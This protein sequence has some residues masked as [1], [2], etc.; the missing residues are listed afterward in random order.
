[1]KA[2]ILNNINDIKLSEVDKPICK[3]DRVL[4]K[5]KAAGICSSDIQRVFKTGAYHYPIILGHEFSG[6]TEDGKR[7]AVFPLLPCHSCESCKSGHYE[8]C[9]NYSYLGSR[10]DGAFSEY[11]TVPKWNLIELN[12][13]VSYE[14]AALLEPAAVGLHA[15]KKIDK[16]EKTMKVAVIGN[17]TIGELIGKWLKVFGVQNIDIIGRNDI[18]KNA[19][20][21][22]CFE[23]VGTTDSLRLAIELTR[24]NGEIVLVGNP[25]KEFQVNQELYWKVLR[26]QLVLHGSWNSSYPTD[27]QECL[28][29][30]KKLDLDSLITHKFKFAEL[31]KG[32]NMMVNKTERF[33]KVLIT[34]E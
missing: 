15:V 24:A 34:V 10:E 16:L 28:A 20:Y 9:S 27:W 2:W 11:V 19:L 22:L 30:I 21:D 33:K 8:T 23:V 31:D 1:M 3:D 29:N 4:V 17:G 26:K 6:I 5:I 7:V 32:L 25:D 14:H 13:D 18:P 12:D